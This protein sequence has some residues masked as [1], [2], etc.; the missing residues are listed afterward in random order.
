MVGA[1]FDELGKRAEQLEAVS[2]DMCAPYILETKGRAPQAEIAF[3]PFL[4]PRVRAGRM[5]PRTAPGVA[6]GCLPS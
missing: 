3:D 5:R 6:A 1:F 4:G 2:M